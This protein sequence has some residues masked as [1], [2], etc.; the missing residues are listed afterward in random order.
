MPYLYAF[1]KTYDLWHLFSLYSAL[2]SFGFLLQN[3]PYS[4]SQ[5]HASL[6]YFYENN[7]EVAN[8]CKLSIYLNPKFYEDNGF[9]YCFGS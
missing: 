7:Q 5:P 8:S 6:P 9:Q 2:D 1:D 3:T 4:I